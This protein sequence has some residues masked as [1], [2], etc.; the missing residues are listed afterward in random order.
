MNRR[1]PRFLELRGVVMIYVS[2]LAMSLVA[3]TLS[4]STAAAAGDVGAARPATSQT[5]AAAVPPATS[6]VRGA[7]T[8]ALKDIPPL[9]TEPRLPGEG[10]WVKE[11]LSEGQDAEPLVYR[12][13]YRPS[14][15]FPNA[16]V[17][18]MLLN[19]KA[20]SARL[21]LGSAEPC[22]QGSLSRVEEESQPGLVAI[23]NAL[24]QTRH[25]GKGGI[26]F[27]GK[28]LKKMDPGVAAIV[29]YNNDTVDILEWSDEIPVSDVR[30]A[31]QLK[32]LIV[33]DGKVVTTTHT[34]GGVVS[35][36]IGLGS[37]LDEA[38][39]VIEVPSETPGEKPSHKLNITSGDLWFIATRSAFG[40]RPDGSLVFAIGHHISTADLAKALVLAGC[41]RA[42]HGDA[43]PGNCVG[44]LYVRDESGQIVNKDRL[45]PA[46]DKSSLERYLKST[47]PKDFVA[48]FRRPAPTN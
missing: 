6:D 27:R 32:H 15:K 30:D 14:E 28:V 37:L 31:R 18:M 5:S 41:V 44:I 21:Y 45:S 36:E 25:A 46:Q 23:T 11:D 4:L 22:R 12:T 35:A 26:V 29:F 34:R 3:L 19:M 17:H 13:F 2:L 10:I 43:N 7:T 24:W 20:M 1:T 8:V 33:K 39:P 48:F 16:I 38:R 40:I 9:Y 47:Y 42:I